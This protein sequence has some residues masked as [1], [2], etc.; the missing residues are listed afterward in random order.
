MFAVVR[1][2]GRSRSA[3]VLLGVVALYLVAAWFKARLYDGNVTALIGF[4]CRPQGS[5][6]SASNQVSLP[7]SAVVFKTGGYDGQFFYYIGR[8]LVG[9]PAAV[10]DSVPFRWAR[11]GL[12]LLSAPLLAAGE[13][14]RVYGLPLTLLV[15][16]LISVG[17]LLRFRDGFRLGVLVFAFNPFSLLSFLVCTADGAALSLGIMGALV[18]ELPGPRRFGGL[19]LIAA[20]LLTKE[21][22]LVAPAALAAAAVLDE[23]RQRWA[24]LRDVAL[25]ALTALPLLIWWKQVGFSFGRAAEHGNFPFA[26]VLAYLPEMDLARAVLVAIL[27]LAIGLGGLLALV[28]KARA[29]GFALL[30]TAALVSLATASEYWPAF[31]NIGRLF[32]PMA[33]VPAL[34]AESQLVPGVRRRWTL[35]LALAWALLLGVLTVVI[36]LR[37]A[38]RRPLPFF[39]VS[40]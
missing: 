4:G 11:I 25:L 5:C 36:V 38:T 40:S 6:Y 33:L 32:T 22:L 23:S 29:A 17:C 37:E 10:V 28:P 24:R 16:H 20:A 34:L 18:L 2:V 8:E 30:G 31:A 27:V 12:P 21:T 14:G 19:V 39:V 13:F 15:L 3:R 35:H 26:G 1:R 7:A 9:G